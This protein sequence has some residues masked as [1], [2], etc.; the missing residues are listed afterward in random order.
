MNAEIVPSLLFPG[1][2]RRDTYGKQDTGQAATQALRGAMP[3]EAGQSLRVLL[4]P[5][6]LPTPEWH[7]AQAEDDP[8]LSSQPVQTLASAGDALQSVHLLAGRP[9]WE[10]RCLLFL[11]L[12]LSGI[13]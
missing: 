13:E 1:N 12:Y 9:G 11:C 2:L 8:L 6:H 3:G 5:W 7:S 10:F 4:S